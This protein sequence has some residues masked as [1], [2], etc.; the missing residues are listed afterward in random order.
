MHSIRSILAI[1]LLA[2]AASVRAL[3]QVT[4][5]TRTVGTM[6]ELLSQIPGGKH[7]MAMVAGINAE[8]AGDGGL[9]RY[10]PSSSA[11][12][13]TTDVFKPVNWNGRWIRVTLSGAIETPVALASGGTG[14]TNAI[15]AARNFTVP[16]Y[17]GSPTLAALSG[18]ETPLMFL[19]TNIA[20]S[21]SILWSPDGASRPPW[22]FRLDDVSDYGTVAIRDS[23][24]T[25]YWLRNFDGRF[26]PQMFGAL[27]DGATDDTAAIQAWID[28]GLLDSYRLT[29]R[30]EAASLFVPPGRYNMEGSVSVVYE[31]ADGAVRN[32]NQLIIHGSGP[33]SSVFVTDRSDS[34]AMF[35]FKELRGFRIYGVGGLGPVS[36]AHTDLPWT[37]PVF[38]QTQDCNEWL[39]GNMTVEGFN[40]GLRLDNGSGN[41]GRMTDV[42]FDTCVVGIYGRG[43]QSGEYRGLRFTQCGVGA[44][45]YL[46]TG[47]KFEF[48]GENNYTSAQSQNSVVR[49]NNATALKVDPGYTEANDGMYAVGIGQDLTHTNSANATAGGTTTIRVPV[50]QFHFLDSGASIVVSGSSTNATIQSDIY[51]TRT[52]TGPS[53][54]TNYVEFTA[55][56]AFADASLVG[57]EIVMAENGGAV[58]GLTIIGGRVDDNAAG[59]VAFGSASNVTIDG[60]FSY[61]PNIYTAVAG[62]SNVINLSAR[63]AG[64]NLFE[65]LGPTYSP[66]RNLF[67]D[68]EMTQG[69]NAFTEYDNL[70]GVTFDNSSDYTLGRGGSLRLWANPDLGESTPGSGGWVRGRIPVDA[71]S[72]VGRDLMLSFSAFCPQIDAYRPYVIGV[73]AVGSGYSNGEATITDGT[74]TV[75][76]T[77]TTS[78]GNITAAAWKFGYFLLDDTST[79]FAV[80]Q[81]GGSGGTVTM[82][83]YRDDGWNRGNRTAYG[84]LSV[85]NQSTVVLGQA[86]NINRNDGASGENYEVTQWD[87][88][89]VRFTVP[90]GT[91]ELHIQGALIGNYS[92]RSGAEPI[93]IDNLT[94]ID[95]TDMAAQKIQA[96]ALDSV[97]TVNDLTT[98]LAGPGDPTADVDTGR[99]YLDYDS[100]DLW[101]QTS[102]SGASGWDVF[103]RNGAS[104]KLS[105]GINNTQV[106]AQQLNDQITNGTFTGS[107]T[108]WSLGGGWTYATN[109]VYITGGVISG[110]VLSQTITEVHSG[111]EYTVTADLGGFAAN[112][113]IV[114]TFV[115]G[116]STITL[117]TYSAPGAISELLTIPEIGTTSSGFL[118]FTL[119]N[120][121]GTA[122][123]YID[124]VTMTLTRDCLRQS[125]IATYWPA[126]TLTKIGDGGR[127]VW[128]GGIDANTPQLQLVMADSAG[129]ESTLWTWTAPASGDFELTADFIYST[130][131]AGRW[132]VKLI[133]HQ[134]DVAID[135]GNF[136][137]VTWASEGAQLLLLATP[138]ADNDIRVDWSQYMTI[139]VP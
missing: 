75:R 109:Q 31:S 110:A 39:M 105:R 35:Y 25:G 127:A 99:L 92:A 78:G 28:F 107:A 135:Q 63:V 14:A 132:A 20:D 87:H 121:S 43:M 86:G 122:A 136:V 101:T 97:A 124:N 80:T 37:G 114:L 112:E 26:T 53:V 106:K 89:S 138:D 4:D 104:T 45:C 42:D 19:S 17:V 74:N 76:L 3:P 62:M 129:N 18:A 88:R 81:S 85:I 24:D 118:N 61:N 133:Q 36:N 70:R 125:P 95:V 65:H 10:D 103:V 94:L 82:T 102:D 64:T 58:N 13:N 29:W 117:G 79:A 71:S 54:R 108:G 27:A 16:Q 57:Q 12:T 44:T 96:W 60:A 52:I 91:T 34:T 56:S 2:A 100:G 23:S 15:A 59:L 6:S 8:D 49:L 119:S 77:L 47:G 9:F 7:H 55:A 40:I 120:S 131:A 66:L 73:T 41:F 5:F 93:Y 116:S 72:L 33:N 134:Q 21:A 137:N 130:T 90:S 68:P 123:T 113:E 67:P 50:N 83:S 115:T 32:S 84:V 126:G 98:I 51:G 139:K 69:T 22:A 11:T 30:G 1:I 38:I 46:L 48:E 128:R 111:S